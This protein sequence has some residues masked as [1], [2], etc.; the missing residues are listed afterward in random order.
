MNL[1]L[2]NENT[3]T[4]IADAIREKS[5][6][7]ATLTPEEMVQAIKDIIS[8]PAIATTEEEMDNLLKTL[9]IGSICRFVGE[10][11]KYATN[12]LYEIYEDM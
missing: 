12:S 9:E 8:G 3:L 6:T 5:K 1:Y 4:N 7:S 11:G 2:I 10:S